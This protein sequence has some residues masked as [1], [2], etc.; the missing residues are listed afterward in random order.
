[1]FIEASDEKRKLQRDKNKKN[2]LNIRS[3]N[4]PKG[5]KLYQ[6]PG[7]WQNHEAS[8]SREKQQIRLVPKNYRTERD[9]RHFQIINN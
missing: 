8:V 6:Q 3:L 9:I 5:Y 7:K 1:M 4:S 2:E